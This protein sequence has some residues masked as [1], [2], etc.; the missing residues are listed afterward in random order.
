[1]TRHST[2]LTTAALVALALP[3]AACDIDVQK[4][5]VDGKAKVGITSPVGNVS[6]PSWDGCPPV[7]LAKLGVSE[8]LIDTRIPPSPS[9]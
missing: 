4:E 7:G 2:L 3:I 8:D 9:P 1:M 5:E 6:V